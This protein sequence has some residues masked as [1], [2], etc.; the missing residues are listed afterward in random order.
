MYT[1]P[2]QPTLDWIVEKFGKNE[3]VVAA[4]TA[5][6]KAGMHFAETTE[7]VGHRYEVRPAKLPTGRVH[8]DHRQH[9][10]GVGARRRRRN[11]P[12]CR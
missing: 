10:P 1:R 8:V 11:W 6:F 7:Q 9:R 4:N 5:A 2:V 3:Q 12:S